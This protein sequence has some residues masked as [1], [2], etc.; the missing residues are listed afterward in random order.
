MHAQF[1]NIIILKNE[2][3]VQADNSDYNRRFQSEEKT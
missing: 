1:F 3:N 2:K